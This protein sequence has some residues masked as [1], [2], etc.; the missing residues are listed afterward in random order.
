[1]SMTLCYPC[2]GRGFLEALGDLAEYCYLCGGSGERYTAEERQ[3][4]LEVLADQGRT[5]RAEMR[6]AAILLDLAGDDI[7]L[8][9]PDFD[10]PMRDDGWEPDDYPEG[11][12]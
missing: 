7:D 2:Q 9:N 10:D 11:I 1:M 6:H 12:R 3:E 4:A 8:P 5:M